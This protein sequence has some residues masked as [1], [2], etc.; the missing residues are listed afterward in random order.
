MIVECYVNVMCGS[1][2]YFSNESTKDANDEGDGKA[3]EDE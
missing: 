3:V 1:K 2:N